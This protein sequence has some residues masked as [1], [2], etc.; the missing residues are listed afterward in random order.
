MLRR[1]A[2]RSRRLRFETITEG[3]AARVLLAIAAWF[4]ILRGAALAQEFKGPPWFSAAR[5]SRQDAEAAD[6][7]TDRL[8]SWAAVY[9]TF[10]AYGQCDDGG[11]AEGYS[12]KIV[13][14][15]TKQWPT[16]AALSNLTKAN[17]EFERFVL[18]HVDGLMSPDQGQII[19]DNAR[20]RCPA[21]AKKLCGRLEAKAKSPLR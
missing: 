21:G 8:T 13:I 3:V 6:R 7:D 18:W 19:I 2:I 10:R 5:C 9:R 16:V 12:G 4:F 14:L 15:L 20:N 1:Q 17:P 11:I